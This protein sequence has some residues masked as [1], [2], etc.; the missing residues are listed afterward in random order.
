MFQYSAW[1]IQLQ[2]KLLW[3]LSERIGTILQ[4]TLRMK[5]IGLTI[6]RWEKTKY[7]KYLFVWWLSISCFFTNFLEK[8]ANPF[9]TKLFIM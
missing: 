9:K 1:Y 8:K 3:C 4:C 2:S 6:Q 5:P 7:F